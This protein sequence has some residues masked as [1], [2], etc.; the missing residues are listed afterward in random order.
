MYKHIINQERGSVPYAHGR[1]RV[2]ATVIFVGWEGGKKKNIC[3]P[4]SS[5]PP[6]PENRNA[7]T[8]GGIILND[9]YLGWVGG[10]KNIITFYHASVNRQFSQ[11]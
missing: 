3:S 8:G 2:S 11:N 1:A 9:P 5:E 10:Y 7:R 6:T 4:N